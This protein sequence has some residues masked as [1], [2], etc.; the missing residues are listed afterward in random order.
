M[1]VGKFGDTREENGRYKVQSDDMHAVPITHQ[2][3]AI[4]YVFGL[5]VL[6]C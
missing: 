6:P 4:T 3:K 1:R 2:T 5:Q